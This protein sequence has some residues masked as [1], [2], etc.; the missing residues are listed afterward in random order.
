MGKLYISMLIVGK[1]TFHLFE[2]GKEEKAE[3]DV[4]VFRS[5]FADKRIYAG[6]KSIRTI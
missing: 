6:S 4:A 3:V 2:V 5:Y 1:L